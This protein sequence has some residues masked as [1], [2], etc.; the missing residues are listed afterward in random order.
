MNIS[1]SPKKQPSLISFE[2]QRFKTLSRKYFEHLLNEF[3]DL[4]LAGPGRRLIFIFVLFLVVT[5]I[6]VASNWLEIAPHLK[7]WFQII[8]SPGTIQ[9]DPVK[10]LLFVGS[11]MGYWLIPFLVPGYYALE[12]AA[13]Y[14]TDI[15]ELENTD[16]ARE[17]IRQISLTGGEKTIHVR[18]GR[19]I[20]EDLKSPVVKIGGPG[21]I[22]VEFDS[23]V[24]FEYPDGRPHVIGPTGKPKTEKNNGDD[25]KD[26][27]ILDGFERFREAIDLR[28][29]YIGDPSG[30]PLIIKG[31]SLDGLPI[32]AVDVRAVY[33][34][35]RNES[36]VN[37]SVPSMEQPYP[38]IARSIQDL[39]Y[40]SSARVSSDGKNPSEQPSAW[41][42]TIQGLIRSAIGEF[43]SENNLTDY[44][45]SFGTPEVELA[46]SQERTIQFQR[47][48]VTADKSSTTQ[49]P[50][51]P[52]PQFH[53]RTELS[54][55]F[56]QLSD[57]FTRRANERGVDL[58][59]IGVGT[60]QIPEK[61]AS[62]IIRGQHE[63][64]W[65]INRENLLRGT[66]QA[67]ET[68]LEEAFADQK[69]RLIQN[70]PLMAYMET[71][72]EEKTQNGVRAL[73]MAYWELLG[74]AADLYYNAGDPLPA[75]LEEGI[76]RI[77]RIIFSEQHYVGERPPSKLHA[78][79]PQPHAEEQR[80][81]APSTVNEARL[82][83]K[84]LRLF[85]GDYKKIEWLI[86]Y[87][88]KKAP[89]S[90]RE[91]TIQYL[92]DHPELCKI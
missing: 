6:T 78:A 1:T 16:I 5:G 81:P 61:I 77:E 26:F 18:G 8:L 69:L 24:L 52:R 70:V 65:K 60:W 38:F 55:I 50:D 57:R 88:N 41:T 73:V 29:H 85:D 40:Q 21:R 51:L 15:F 20:E 86:E 17:F 59:W 58:H 67:F 83:S 19:I 62:D 66:E 25:E 49:P 89:G 12:M 37:K 82:Y 54:S 79:P 46:E 92:L 48:E 2:W 91:Q 14:L 13:E 75:E 3:F 30:E 22:V 27:V 9:L 7:I 90:S 36:K 45:A 32:S 68:I 28:D 53:P 80:P 71:K 56:N 4:S 31:R 63:Q 64:A 10:E 76:S 39:V 44:L 74:E 47:F 84:L 43:M 72:Q 42:N 11:L 23:A 34:I 35:R 33:S 87:E